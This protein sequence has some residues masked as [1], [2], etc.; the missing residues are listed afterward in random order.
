MMF[1]V[2]RLRGRN[3][4]VLRVSYPCL[5]HVCIGRKQARARYSLSQHLHVLLSAAYLKSGVLREE[6]HQ[7][8]F[9]ITASHCWEPKISQLFFYKAFTTSFAAA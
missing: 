8:I 7:R 2:L 9:V 3:V 1:G 5:V 4:L 6:L